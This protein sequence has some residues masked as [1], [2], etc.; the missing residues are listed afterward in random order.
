ML[1]AADVLSGLFALPDWS[2]QAVAAVLA[3]GF[4]VALVVAW[5]FQVTPNGIR[6]DSALVE[7]AEGAQGGTR[8]L[9]AF[10]LIALA[11]AVA[12]FAV[13]KFWWQQQSMSSAPSLAVLP[14][15]NLSGDDG[16]D[17][18]A[19]GM[20]DELIGLLG[21]VPELQMIGRTS[22]FQFKGKQRDLRQIARDLGVTHVVDGSVRRAGNTVRISAEL[23]AADSGLLLWSE[24]YDRELDDILRVQT[25]IG[26]SVVAELKLELLGGALEVPAQMVR[27]DAYDYYLKGLRLR[28]LAGQ[29]SLAQAESYFQQ[30][31]A[32]DPELAVAWDGLAATYTNQVMS[33]VRPPKGGVELAKRTV[34][35]TLSLDP[36]LA[37]A[38]YARGFLY[39]VFDRDWKAAAKSFERSL[40]LEP[41][42]PGTLSGFALLNA[43]KRDEQQARRLINQAMKL[44][45][46]NMTGMHNSAFIAYMAR[47]YPLAQQAFERAVSYAGGAYTRGNARLSLVLLQLGETEK[48]LQMARSEPGENWRLAAESSVLY[49][50][51]L[52]GD[53]QLAAL[54]ARFPD[55]APASIARVHVI[56]GEMTQAI[57]WLDR[58]LA[59]QD[60]ELTWVM[61]DPLFDAL[62]DQPSFKAFVERAEYSL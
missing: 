27:T 59:V 23:L 39:M 47:D 44:D 15:A 56:R 50:Q 9:D 45:P 60:P 17:Y 24:T 20:S 2:M 1:Q 43:A 11:V 30:A 42:H 55:R 5:L 3:V 58:A 54:K 19:E 7:E 35:R 57:E 62:R 38:H 14:F 52:G 8:R 29:T 37:N 32:L 26:R 16:Q 53:E 46:L 33:G 31:I 36:D 61:A 4:P 51:G 41:N 6:L 21:R 18:F 34:E 10:I 49:V 48:A 13:D 25:D 22:S 12:L 28:R 40:Q